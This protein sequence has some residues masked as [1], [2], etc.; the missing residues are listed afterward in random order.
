MGVRSAASAACAAVA[1]FGATEAQ[2]TGYMLREQSGSMLGQAFAGQNAYAADPSVIFHNPAG[3][4]ALD[5]RRASLVVNG[6]RPQS[7]F[8]NDGSVGGFPLGTEEGGDS[9]ED[10]IVPGLYAMDS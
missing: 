3:M 8:D 9:A 5:G 4:S 7:D 6:I 10:A 1:L 2:A